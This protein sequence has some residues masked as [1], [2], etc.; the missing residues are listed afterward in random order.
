MSDVLISAGG[1]HTYYG[2]SHILHGVDFI[3]R[4][5]ETVGLMGRNGMGKTTLLRSVLGLVRPRA[6]EVR[7][8]GA[9]MT[10]A[11][12]MIGIS[13]IF[14]LKGKRGDFA[15]RSLK[16]GVVVGAIASV[17]QLGLGH[18]HAIQVAHTQPEKL[19]AIEKFIKQRIPQTIIPGFGPDASGVSVLT[20]AARE[21]VRREF[22]LR[23]P[24]LVNP[25]GVLLERF[26][27]VN[28]DLSARHILYTGTF[29]PWKGLNTLVEAMAYLPD[30]RLTLIGGTKREH[31]DALRVQ[32]ERLG[33]H[34]RVT[35]REYVP[36]PQ[37]RSAL[38]S[39][40]VLAM[41]LTGRFIEPTYFTS[42]SKA[43]EYM[44]LAMPIVTTD[45]PTM[46]EIFAHEDSALL[47]PPDDPKGLADALRR[48]L[49]DPALAQRLAAGARR[50]AERFTWDAR[51]E[52]V[53]KFIAE[54]RP[55]ECVRSD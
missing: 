32:V 5:G 31:V 17:A 23:Q 2:R 55:H 37:L 42:P 46:R 41:P 22:R 4:R 45:L 1:I 13:A 12:F 34:G 29:T 18:Y 24:M 35:M 50:S 26:P 36:Q 53:W 25:V 16:A 39:A 19:A 21:V 11:F 15:M 47:A 33:L 27:P 52:R 54:W 6:G 48:V 3:V 20:A 7:I 14:L 10:A 30:A 9:V 51:A 40:S 28:F 43:F 49:G 8:C 44:A 38:E